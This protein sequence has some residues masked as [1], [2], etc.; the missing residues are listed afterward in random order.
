MEY[1]VRKTGEKFFKK[2]EVWVTIGNILKKYREKSYN[3]M[4]PSG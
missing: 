4:H 3:L 1:S 2:K